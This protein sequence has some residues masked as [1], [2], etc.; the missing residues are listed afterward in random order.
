MGPIS[1]ILKML[2]IIIIATA[3]ILIDDVAGNHFIHYDAI[4]NSDVTSA[5]QDDRP[6]VFIIKGEFYYKLSSRKMVS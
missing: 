6:L 4:F 2:I 5:C 1:S 3:K